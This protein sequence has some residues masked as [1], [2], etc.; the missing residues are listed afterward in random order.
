MPLSSAVWSHAH[1]AEPRIECSLEHLREG[2]T[3]GDGA[4]CGGQESRPRSDHATFARLSSTSTVMASHPRFSMLS[5]ASS[6][7]GDSP[8]TSTTRFSIPSV[9]SAPRPAGARPNIYDRN[10]NKTRAAEVSASAFAFMFSE[11]VQYTQKRVSGIADLERRCV[12]CFPYPRVRS[13][14]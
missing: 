8:A 4:R 7:A 9:G 14:K 3:R 6:A 5:S 12:S 2:K 10:L 11:M 1:T 13:L